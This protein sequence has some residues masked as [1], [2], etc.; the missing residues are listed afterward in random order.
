MQAAKQEALKTI[1]QLPDDTD[2]HEIMYRLYVL[3]NSTPSAPVELGNWSLGGSSFIKSL[4]ALPDG[5]TALVGAQ[6][7]NVVDTSNPA[8]MSTILVHDT[9]RVFAH[10]HLEGTRLYSDDANGTITR[11]SAWG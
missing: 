9:G 2:M 10:Q 11:P 7:L 6:Q 4:A 1:G 3:D 8:A 5:N